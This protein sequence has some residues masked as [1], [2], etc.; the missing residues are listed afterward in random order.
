[1]NDDRNESG[2]SSE[3]EKMRLGESFDRNNPE[4]TEIRTK[5][6]ALLIAINTSTSDKSR[7][8]FDQLFDHLGEGSIVRPPF[9]CEFGKTI[10]IGDRSFLNSGV[11]MLDNADIRIGNHVMIGPGTH[12]YTPTHSL[13]YRERRNWQAYSQPIVVEDDVW[14]GGN[15]CICQGVKIGARS[16]IAAGSVVTEDVPC[17]TLV[18][19]TPAKKIRQLE[20]EDKGEMPL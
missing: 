15:V 13:D 7:V 17:D 14:I 11:I 6:E 3:F 2:K 16:V 1:M 12:F 5:A 18:G 19:G 9:Q 10:S 20:F 4:I 8:L